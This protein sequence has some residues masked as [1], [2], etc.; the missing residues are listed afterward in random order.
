LL[1][2]SSFKENTIQVREIPGLNIVARLHHEDDVFSGVFNSDAS[3]VLS[4][5]RDNTARIWDTRTWQEVT[6]VVANDF[7]YS[8]LYSPD[9]KFFVTASGDGLAR[10]WAAGLDAMVGVACQRLS[11][12]LTADEWRQYLGSV[13][14]AETCP[15]QALGKEHDG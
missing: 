14:P 6:R 15:R 7:M 2:V 3:M 9:E 13:K 1:L 11:R 5:A 10:V 8:A 4:A 12:N